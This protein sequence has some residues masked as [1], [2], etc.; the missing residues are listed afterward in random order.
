MQATNSVGKK[1]T[2]AKFQPQETATP[3]MQP[4]WRQHALIPLLLTAAMTTNC[5]AAPAGWELRENK[6]RITGELTFQVFLSTSADDNS[7]HGIFEATGTCKATE[8]MLRVVYLSG[9]DKKLGY[10]LTGSIPAPKVVSRVAIDG[11]VTSWTSAISDYTNEAIFTFAPKSG[12]EDEATGNAFM[13]AILGTSVT[14]SSPAEISRAK[15]IKIEMPLNNGD[16][17]ILE[18]R[19]QDPGF[20]RFVARCGGTFREPVRVAKAATRPAAVKSPEA[21]ERDNYLD[22]YGQPSIYDDY[23]TLYQKVQKLLERTAENRDEASLAKYKELAQY[24]DKLYPVAGK[25]YAG[26]RVK[27]DIQGQIDLQS[28]AEETVADLDGTRW[29]VIGPLGKTELQQRETELLALGVSDKRPAQSPVIVKP[30]DPATAN[31]PANIPPPRLLQSSVSGSSE[32]QRDTAAKVYI[33]G[34]DG[35]SAPAIVSRVEPD[36][37]EAANKAKLQGNVVLS[38]VVGSDGAPRNIT[39]VRGLGLG[40]DEKAI[41]AVGKWRF[42]PALKAGRPVPVRATIT[43]NFRHL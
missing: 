36:Y 21:I 34:Q 23:P 12:D 30:F 2:V 31:L 7:R 41:E 3:I 19:P 43:V 4:R 27:G 8:L 33:V 40:L 5:V 24:I 16:R 10:Q 28:P 35:V 11:R 26:I 32:Q 18:I 25:G 37:T 13:G 29:E 9:F 42:R 15:L 39:V 17:P 38:L 20:Q 6:D 14:D 1:I 22:R